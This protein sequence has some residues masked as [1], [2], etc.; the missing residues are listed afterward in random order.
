[1]NGY[2]NIKNQEEQLE[3]EQLLIALKK[4]Y[5]ETEKS[6]NERNLEKPYL[7][8][9]NFLKTDNLIDNIFDNY[10][11]N[12]F[13]K[14]IHKDRERG[15]IVSISATEFDKIY[16]NYKTKN[17]D[18]N[19]IY[20]N[21]Y[22]VSSLHIQSDYLFDIIN[23]KLN[24]YIK[25]GK[26]TFTKAIARKRNNKDFIPQIIDDLFDI[27]LSIK[28]KIKEK[29]NE[30]EYY[31]LIHEKLNQILKDLIVSYYDLLPSK[32]VSKIKSEFYNLHLLFTK[33]DL[34]SF[35]VAVSIENK[36]NKLRKKLIEKQ[37]IEEIN[38]NDFKK[39]FSN[40]YITN[41]IN[42]IGEAGQL[43]YFI[44]RFLEINN[45]ILKRKKP[46]RYKYDLLSKCFSINK[47]DIS[48]D[49]FKHQK[50]PNNKLK[51]QTIDYILSY[52]PKE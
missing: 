2:F 8:L 44:N 36:L 11:T 20:L 13:Y 35:K 18:F 12:Y 10:Q 42:W 22:L 52:L 34:K 41:K 28:N 15:M 5:L 6:E 30:A 31:I 29:S 23:D 14:I 9:I 1:M 39:V 24:Q 47:Q 40:T 48:P 46:I 3:K 38:L 37:L 33:N 49:K 19:T 7:K 25:E 45:A 21:Q 17:L 32:T 16:K 27:N 4:Q 50:K 26:D 51:I 43:Y